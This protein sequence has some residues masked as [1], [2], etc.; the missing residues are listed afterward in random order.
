[1]RKQFCD[2]LISTPRH[3][4]YCRAVVSESAAK[5]G[6]L[7]FDGIAFDDPVVP[8]AR[9]DLRLTQNGTARFR[10]KKKQVERPISYVDSD[11]TMQY[12]PA[13]RRDDRCSE[14]EVTV[15]QHAHVHSDLLVTKRKQRGASL[16]FS[17]RKEGARFERA[18]DRTAGR[19]RNDGSYWTQLIGLT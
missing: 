13:A 10:E 15:M 18:S 8:H 6:H 4:T 17:T 1:M 19:R 3:R 12:L 7:S 16:L 14:S 2:E 9:D 11:S 5:C